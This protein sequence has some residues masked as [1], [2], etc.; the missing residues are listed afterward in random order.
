[1]HTMVVFAL[2]QGDRRPSWADKDLDTEH[3]DFEHAQAPFFEFPIMQD[4]S[5]YDGRDSPSTDR[6]VSYQAFSGAPC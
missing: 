1:M 6:V 5:V 3:F 2:T 4:G